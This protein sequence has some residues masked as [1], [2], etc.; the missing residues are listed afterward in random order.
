MTARPIGERLELRNQNDLLQPRLGARDG[1]TQKSLL[2]TDLT[3][4]RRCCKACNEESL[5]KS[6][7]RRQPFRAGNEHPVC[8]DSG[9]E[10]RGRKTKQVGDTLT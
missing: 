8:Y 9:R 6:S 10:A 7:R 1:R 4:F 3:P 5:P 2:F